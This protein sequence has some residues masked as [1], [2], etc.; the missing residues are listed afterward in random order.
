M[1]ES[2]QKKLLRVRPPRVKITYDIETGGAIEK[3]ELPFIIGIL[4]DLQGDENTET[5]KPALK[6]R[7]LIDIDRDNFTDVM[8]AINPQINLAGIGNVLPGVKEGETLSVTLSFTSIDQFE[9]VAVI[10]QIPLLNTLYAEKKQIQ[11]DPAAAA[12]VATIDAAINAQLNR[13]LHA[14][15]F[16]KLEASWRGLHYL[17]SGTETGNLLKLR[18]WNVSKKELQEDFEK[19]EVF[20]Q[21][22]LFKNIYEAEYGTYGGQPYS[23]LV[24]DFFFGI[25][26]RDVNFLRSIATVA[27]AVHTP[28]IFAADISLFGLDRFSDIIKLK[29]LTKIF[30]GIEHQAYQ[31]FKNEE[32]S[33]YVSLVLPTVM[34][35]KP[36]GKENGLTAGFYFEEETDQ[37]NQCLLGNAA[38]ILAERIANAFSLYS[39]PAAIR[40]KEGGGLVEGLPFCSAQNER[41]VLSVF[42]PTS[43][44]LTAASAKQLEE[45]GFITLTATEQTGCAVFFSSFDKPHHQK[46]TI[47]DANNAKISATLP[48]IL[49]ASRFAHYIKVIMREK[50]GS[51]LTR[52]NVENYLNTWIANYVLLD[53]HAT[54]EVKAAYPLRGAKIIVT[55]VPGLVGSYSATIFLKPYFQLEEL[56]TSIRLVASLP[57]E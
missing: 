31:E 21:S 51:F 8:K 36:Y 42:G 39:W 12:R 49:T 46:K 47:T 19:T 25:S 48:Y 28:L 27:A 57:Q 7:K 55:E 32:D 26:E 24:G 22:A 17:V 16:V 5:P 4:A 34:M 38:Y 20:D 52:A 15:V 23:L 18:V 3:R 45:L 9:P 2:I 40:G 14:P 43:A 30:D 33:R 29:N 44:Q 11:T 54:Q 41:G 13:I 56:T 35:R 6:E 53:D 1:T 50:I 10:Q 37:G